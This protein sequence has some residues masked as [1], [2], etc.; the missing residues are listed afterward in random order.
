MKIALF[1]SCSLI[2]ISSCGRPYEIDT[3]AKKQ[4]E[5]TIS[6][7]KKKE[8]LKIPSQELQVEIVP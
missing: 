6:S 3:Q 1:I 2:F 7:I 4:T 5:D 8:N